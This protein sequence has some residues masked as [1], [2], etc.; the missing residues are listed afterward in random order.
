MTRAPW[1]W[2]IGGTLA[3]VAL[4]AAAG[5]VGR[6]ALP[7][8]AVVRQLA[9]RGRWELAGQEIDKYLARRPS[10]ADALLLAA[11]IAGGRQD[12][13][14][15]VA[16]LERVPAGSARQA[17]ALVRQGQALR[18]LGYG[19]RA[20]A[21]LRQA[22]ELAGPNRALPA[23]RQS[24]LAELVSLCHVEQRMR[25]ARELLWRMYP[26]HH[27]KWRLLINLARLQNR[28]PNAQKMIA[29]L[30]TMVA[31]DPEDID[32]CRA[33]AVSHAE[34]FD[35]PR[36]DDEATRC[37][38]LRPDDPGCVAVLLECYLAEQRWAEMD[39][40]LERPGVDAGDPAVWRLRARRRE[41]A[42]DLAGAEQCFRESLRLE[43]L[44]PATHFQF[45]Q[46]LRRTRRPEAEEHLDQF[47]ELRQHQNEIE[48]FLTNYAADSAAAWQR[49]KAADCA[50][51]AEHCRVLGR[52]E[53]A[54]AWLEEALRQQPD[55]A[56]ARERLRALRSGPPVGAP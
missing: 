52:A 50:E 41:A 15:C 22:L 44:H 17:E 34:L 2:W 21:V 31:K 28:S 46:L 38:A 56:D 1:L 54:R 36:A 13:E 6:R 8:L 26:E 9:D 55:L 27:E 48:K 19:R 11:R 29:L 51:M 20:E 53:E 43:P 40:L 47:R 37:L 12:L 18:A 45:A 35:W 42:G 25:E 5:G 10:D 49:P 32:A 33:R 3:A 39:A 16:L 14:R 4:A 24:A 30:D 7:R 23:D